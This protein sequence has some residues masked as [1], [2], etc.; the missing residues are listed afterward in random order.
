MQHKHAILGVSFSPDGARVLTYE[1]TTDL[2]KAKDNAAHLWDARTGK[3]IG[4][5]MQHPFLG[6]YRKSPIFS[7]SGDVILTA[8][9]DSTIRLWDGKTGRARGVPLKSMGYSAA[10]SPDGRF[11]IATGCTT[12]PPTNSVDYYDLR[13][14]DASNGKPVGQPA[15]LNTVGSTLAF[16]PDGERILIGYNDK[17][18]QMWDAGTL[19]PIG[20]PLEHQGP[21]THVSFSQNGKLFLTVSGKV[22]RTWD[23]ATRRPFGRALEQRA[24]IEDSAFS[25]DGTVVITKSADGAARLWDVGTGR[26]IGPALHDGGKVA[27]LAYSPDGRTLATASDKSVRLIR[28]PSPV[29]GDPKQLALWTEVMSGMELDEY[30]SLRVLDAKSWQVRR[31]RLAQ[32]GGPPMP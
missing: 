3:P 15:K 11:V 5:P 21:V 18:A 22:V 26:P 29:A 4:E 10:F 12:K 13:M 6:L 30:R 20:S 9:G 1:G 24:N 25:P 27:C 16:S 19:K 17:T 8:G 32:L 23:A 14:W 31:A 28:P 2:A 7:P